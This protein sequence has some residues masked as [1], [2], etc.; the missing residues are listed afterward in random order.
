MASVRVRTATG[1]LFAALV[2]TGIYATSYGRPG[3]VAWC[4][5]VPVTLLAAFELGSM[6]KFAAPGRSVL[7]PI[8]TLPAA[9]AILNAFWND[10]SPWESVRLLL[11]VMLATALVGGIIGRFASAAPALDQPAGFLLGRLP[12]GFFAAWVGPPVAALALVHASFGTPALAALIVLSKLGDIA[13]YFV[14]KSIG[15]SHPFPKLSP[16]KTTAGC[17]ASLVVGLAGGVGAT[18]WDVLPGEPS[19]LQGALVG[20]AINIA[21]QAADLFESYMKRTS[22]VKDSSAMAGASGGVLDVVDSL[23]FT[24]PLGLVLFALLAP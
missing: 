15:K 21:A 16:G 22:G 18:F 5:A 10:A 1:F 8:L 7:I 14:G 6:G 19:M 24:V 20:A 11:G 3:L 2:S 12:L 23:L 17:V 9:F 13:G 4:I